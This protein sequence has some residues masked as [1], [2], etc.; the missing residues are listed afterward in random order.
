MYVNFSHATDESIDGRNEGP[1]D[2]VQVTY[3]QIRVSP[4][5][6]A[7]A[8]MSHSSKLWYFF[9]DGNPYTDVTIFIPK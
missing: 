6:A 2:F 5:G 4:D 8:F 9:G 3:D 1:Y 7:I